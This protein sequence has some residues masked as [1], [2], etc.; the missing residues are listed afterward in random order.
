MNVT[1]EFPNNDSWRFIDAHHEFTSSNPAAESFNGFYSINAVNE[2]MEDMDFVGVKIGDVN[3]N[4][5]ANSLLGAE[6]RTT[7]G[8]FSLTSP[9]RFV[10]A[11]ENVT[12]TFTAAEMPLLRLLCSRL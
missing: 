10:E 3:G 12:V 6:S 5:Q 2:E 1:T 8:T 7:D 11:G 9:D 4:A